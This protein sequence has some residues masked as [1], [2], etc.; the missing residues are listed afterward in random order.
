MSI[1]QQNYLSQPPVQLSNNQNHSRSASP[2]NDNL[3]TTMNEAM[4]KR[5]TDVESALVRERA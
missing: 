5:L 4:A 3:I 1:T 2:F